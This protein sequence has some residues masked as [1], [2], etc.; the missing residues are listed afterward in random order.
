MIS[1]FPSEVAERIIDI[2]NDGG[3]DVLGEDATVLYGDQNRVPTT[4][5][6]CVEPGET[7]RTLAGVPKRTEN[8]LVAYIIIYYAKVDTNQ[9]TKRDTDKY[10]EGIVRYLDDNLTLEL[11]G[12]GGIVIHGH[13]TNINPG[14][15]FRNQGSTLMNTVRL[16]WVGKTKTIL[17]A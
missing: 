15:T 7:N 16:T 2:L 8:Q 14:Y 10:A 11:N 6:I 9:Q 5:T 17:G 3:I 12:D 1:Q 4:P 13:V